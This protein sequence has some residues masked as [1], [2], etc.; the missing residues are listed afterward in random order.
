MP[1]EKPSLT[2]EEK[3]VRII[4]QIKGGAM[5]AVYVSVP[6]SVELLDYDNMETAD[7]T[8]EEYI[9]YTELEEEIK[10]LTPVW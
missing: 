5:Q 7:E 4:V 1:K 3:P 2:K 10:T 9:S 6:V 8:S